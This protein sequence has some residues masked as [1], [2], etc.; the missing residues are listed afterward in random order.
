[1]TSGLFFTLRKL[2]NVQIHWATSTI[3]TCWFG[4][5]MSLII[6]AVLTHLG[7]YHQDWENELPMLPMDLF[8]AFVASFFS[9]LAQTCMVK[10]FNYE[11]PT[12]IA[13]TKTVDVLFA[14]ILQY[15]FL[16]LIIDSFEIIGSGSILLSTIIILGFKLL[17][18]KYEGYVA[19]A[20]ETLSTSS[21]EDM[22]TER[23]LKKNF[24]L[25]LIFAKF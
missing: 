11:N 4:I 25:K 12:K 10:A 15:I 14:C 13:I 5:P 8:Y 6:S 16:G 22:A 2:S 23:I 19:Q 21:A 17:D 7:L 9:C 24:F 18:N 3:Y 1:M 20:Q